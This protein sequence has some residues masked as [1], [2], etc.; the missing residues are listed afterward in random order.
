[1]AAKAKDLV[2]IIRDNPGC[3]ATIDNDSWT[4][5]RNVPDPP[6]FE[7]WTYEKQEEWMQAQELA[8]SDDK[9]RPFTNETYQ[10]G[11]CY[12]GDILLALAEIVGIK[13]ESV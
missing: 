2:Q 13:V 1:M 3:I 11:S 8:S 4:L 5:K 10:D 12:G 6:D 9:L 7:N